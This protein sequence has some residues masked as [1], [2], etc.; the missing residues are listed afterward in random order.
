MNEL[1]TR[2]I[3]LPLI[4]ALI[5]LT[6]NFGVLAND[7]MV[8]IEAE[9][10]IK[11]E[12][13]YLSKALGRPE[14]SG[15]NCI[16]GWNNKGHAVEWEIEIPESA[17]YKVVLRHANGR[18]WTTFRD[19]KIDNQYP[20][21]AFEKIAFTQSGGFSKEENNW[22]NY[23]VV[24]EK[25]RPVLIQINKGK[26]SIRMTNLGGMLGDD[27]ATNL[28]CIGFLGANGDPNV[29]GRPGLIPA[30]A[31]PAT[32][33]PNG[34]RYLE[35]IFADIQRSS[36]VYGEAVNEKGELQ[37]LWIDIYQPLGD[38]AKL[39]PA[40]MFIHG[41]SFRA[42]SKEE[43]WDLAQEFAK[44]GYVVASIDYRLRKEPF[45]DIATT[46]IDASKDAMAAFV[47]LRD[48]SE[49]YRI[50]KE[51]IAIGGASA[52]GYLAIFLGY[53]PV[54]GK[55]PEQQKILSVISIYG[56]DIRMPSIQSGPPLLII[57]GTTDDTVPY[58]QSLS[59]LQKVQAA[60]IY[61]ELY[62]MENAGHSY[63]N[64]YYGE[65]VSRIAKFLYRYTGNTG[66]SP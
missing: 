59:L 64:R 6:Q 30:F 52:G 57:H 65:I 63:T 54:W 34:I 29:L 2:K 22:Q 17:L 55:N 46:V 8:I 47:W 12:N 53:D 31:L 32:I 20:A 66:V 35:P 9:N 56:G 10:F 23:T 36:L 39:R 11:E 4:I 61:G 24:D 50:N 19:F 37:K 49:K 25:Q 58:S 5:L 21:Q 44:R 14:A 48:N 1:F 38:S 28:D 51:R 42:G 41:G 40:V 60:G 62:T 13:G 15:N 16:I 3:I 33:I 7:V 27:G 18:K 26:H 45:K 43:M